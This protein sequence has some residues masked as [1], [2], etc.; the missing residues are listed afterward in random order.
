ML[1]YHHDCMIQRTV[2]LNK[3][4]LESGFPLSSRLHE[5]VY[6]KHLHVHVLHSPKVISLLYTY[7][8]IHYI[9]VAVIL[10]KEGNTN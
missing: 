1:L 8:Y 7:I 10:I 3:N 6:K 4:L 5:Q 2:D 9:H